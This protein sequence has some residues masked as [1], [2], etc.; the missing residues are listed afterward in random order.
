LDVALVRAAYV[1]VPFCRHHCG[2][3]D[4]AVVAGR[5]DRAK[6][7]VETLSREMAGLDRPHPVETIF[8]GGG[9]P[10]YLP[11][12]LLGGLLN[13]VRT[14]LPLEDGGEWS[15]ESTPD[16]LDAERV[17][18]LADHGV[19]RVSIGA[20][21]F[22]A[23]SLAALE[24]QHA[25][26]DIA[27]AIDRVKRRFSNWSLDLI[28]GVP[29]QTLNDWQADLMH[30]VALEPPHLSCYGL[31]FEKGTPLWKEQQ[32]GRVRAAEEEVERAMYLHAHDRLGALGYEHYEIS[33][34][35]QP[36][37]RCRHNETYWANDPYLGFG[38]GAAR[39]VAGRRELNTRS[40]DEYVSRV[41]AGRSPVI[42][43]ET[44]EGDDKARE[45]MSVQLRRHDGIDRRDFR[46]R[47]GVELNVLVGDSLPRLVTLGLLRDDGQSVALTREGLC[48]ADTVIAE[49]WA[50]GATNPS[51]RAAQ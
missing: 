24:R 29:G 51:G 21:S 19:N 30:A 47:T 18:V 25:P 6:A 5:D 48:V 36:G 40:L 41:T 42:Q 3:C 2:Y 32:S 38:L 27:L 23:K 44:L 37:Q 15:V 28:F 46:Q 7:Y 31:T 17:A 39:Y 11:V 26:E 4:F 9:T 16:S 50:G 35:A 20:Q 10:T 1:H 8:I 33:N 12:D 13:L 34:Y 45:T 43:S 14:W 22:N 49:L